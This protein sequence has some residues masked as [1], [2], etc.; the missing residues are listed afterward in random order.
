MKL[1]RRARR[2]GSGSKK[3]PQQARRPGPGGTAAAAAARRRPH[4]EP[5]STAKAEVEQSSSTAEFSFKD[6]AILIAILAVI[7]AVAGTWG[8][9]DFGDM[10]GYYTMAAD[11]VWQGHLY[12][13]YTPD[14]VN[15]IDMIPYQGHYYLQ[16]GPLPILFHLAAQVVGLNL[17]DRVAS[18]LAGLISAWLFLEITLDLRRRHL[19]DVPK[20]LCRWFVFAFALATPTALVAWRGTVYNESIAIAAVGVLAAFLAFLYYERERSPRWAV[21]SGVA[22]GGAF[23]TRATVVLYAVPFFLALAAANWMTHRNVGKLFRHLA[24]F[25]LPI[26]VAGLAQMAYNQARFGSPFDFG[27]QYK[28]ESVTE[29]FKT[30]SLVRV[31]ENLGHYIF[32]LPK[33]SA[34]FPW[35]DHTGWEPRV[36]TTFAEGTSS[37]LLASPFLLLVVLVVRI[38]RRGSGSWNDL[39]T[40]AALA[41]GA[42]LMQFSVMLCFAS[43][44]RRYMHDCLPLLTVA[45]FLGAA[46]LSH[47]TLRRWAAP[48][49]LVIGFSALLHSHVAFYESFR[50]PQPDLNVT[51]AF[52]AAAPA[53][54]TVAPGPVLDQEEAMARNDWATVLLN[55]RRYQEALEQFTRAG[56]LMPD[57]EAIAKNR[58]LAARMAHAQGGQARQTSLRKP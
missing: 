30:F 53:I 48:A 25:S 34:D 26:L 29:G 11:A 33:P 5:G 15:L 19:P 49:W 23:L 4:Q 38:L 44:S 35:L 2:V 50:S 31:P 8:Q 37:I 1:G 13:S 20:S 58:D 6:K 9:F 7:Y 10:M 46:T 16:W 54:R 28:P 56:E 22:I 40:A 12:I 42:G 43:A 55:H 51:R 41:T 47:Q 36:H 39:K 3:S 27:L 45:A 24:V 21:L 57:S 14:K 18:L 32:S 17:S 52:V